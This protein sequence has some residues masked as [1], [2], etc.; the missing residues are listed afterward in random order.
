M[1]AFPNFDKAKAAAK[2]KQ[3]KPI[4]QRSWFARCQVSENGEPI[5]NV[6]NTLLALREDLLFKNLFSYDLML[7]AI[8]VKQPIPTRNIDASV[9]SFPRSVRDTDYTSILE[10]LQL[11][12]LRRLAS[13]TVRQAI[14]LR[15]RECSYHPVRIFLAGLQW[16]GTQ[17]LDNWLFTYLGAENSEYTRGIGKFFLISMIA[18]ICEPGC[19]AD[20]MMIL[21]G[22]QGAKKST[23]C[24]ILGGEWFSDN[25]PDIRTAGKDVSQHVKAKW[26]IEVAELSALDKSEATALKAFVTRTTERYRP[27]YGYAE[28][29]EPRQCVFI[30]T[31]NK[32]MYLRD[33]TGGRRFWPVKVGKIDTDGLAADRDQLLAEAVAAFGRG[34]NSGCKVYH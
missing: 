28:V 33:E 1:A 34:I 31:T 24:A 19:K 20:Y 2:V 17:R 25:L 27:S 18:R 14:D 4:R 11:V 22:P 15:A 32:G 7:Q 5:P 10:M 23:A 6:A 9:E 21:E 26:L 3:P 16:D 29:I 8:M 30:G 13:A 12:G